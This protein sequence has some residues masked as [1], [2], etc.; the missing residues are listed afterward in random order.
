MNNVTI[1]GKMNFEAKISNTKNGKMAMF[2]LGVANGKDKE[3]K[4][5]YT[6]IS[7]KTFK[8]EYAESLENLGKGLNLVCVGRMVNETYKDK[9]GKNVYSTCLIA[10]YIGQEL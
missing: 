3:G 4:T 2:Q 5:M 1:T 10:D 6:N 8:N 9:E 7:V